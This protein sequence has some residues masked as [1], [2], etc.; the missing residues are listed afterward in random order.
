MLKNVTCQKLLVTHMEI[1]V[2]VSPLRP[3][4]GD[5]GFVVVSSPASTWTATTTLALL[6]AATCSSALSVVF[7]ALDSF[8]Y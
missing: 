2:H 3:P 5:E 1:T 4:N 7:N 6:Q 8:I